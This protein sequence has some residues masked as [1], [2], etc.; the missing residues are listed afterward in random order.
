MKNLSFFAL[1]AVLFVFGF[2]ACKNNDASTNASDAVEIG[3]QSG[4]DYKVNTKTSKIFWSGSKP[5]GIHAGTLS[6]SDGTVVVANENIVGGNFTID[7]NSINV[8]DLE[9]DE[10]LYLEGHLKGSDDKNRDDFFNVAK[11]PTA[12][13]EISKVTKLEND[14]ISN[15]IVYGN[16][17]LKDSTK[18]ISFKAKVSMSEKGLN[19]KSP[20]FTINRTDFGIKYGSKNF[21]ENLGDRFIDDN[22]SLRLEVQA[23][24]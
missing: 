19:V 7:M 6:L 12:K 17:T 9:G 22:I 11:Y 21:F 10:K 24:K 3:E 1:I 15:H 2:Q 20:P 8:T 5:A 14:S 18:L 4:V 23:T 13:F 16:L